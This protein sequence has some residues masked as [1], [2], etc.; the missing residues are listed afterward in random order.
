M[1]KNI[2]QKIITI[3]LFILTVGLV[4]FYQQKVIAQNTPDDIAK[5]YNIT[6]PIKELNNC[7]NYAECRTFCEDPINQT[8]CVNFAKT[9]GFYHEENVDK[10]EIQDAAKIELGCTDI[11]SCKTICQN[12]AN[13]DKC[14]AFAKKHNINGGEGENPEKKEIVEKAKVALGCD[15]PLSCRSICEKVENRQKCDDFAKKAGL[16]GGERRTGP[17]GCTSEDSCRTFCSD[18]N[19]FQICSNFTKGAKGIKGP[20]EQFRGPGGCTSEETCKKFCQDHPQECRMERREG[21]TGINQQNF[22]SQQEACFKTPGC[23]W[24]NNTCQCGQTGNQG[25]FGSSGKPFETEKQ[26]MNPSNFPK[27]NFNPSSSNFTPPSNPQE[28]CSKRGCRWDNN[29]CRCG[30]TQPPSAPPANQNQP[31]PSNQSDHGSSSSGPKPEDMCRQKPGCNWQD[32]TCKCSDVKGVSTGP[33]D[34][35]FRTVFQIINSLFNSQ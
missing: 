13:I 15:S 9:K 27:Q 5:K 31:P 22:N 26:M 17:G 33:N 10:K 3:C 19:N 28:E 11:V 18:P 8:T 21:Q 1:R 4:F 25:T 6:F 16:R 24:D 12:E 29:S 34:N 14:S 20:E 32:N 23:R 2:F 7:K 35:F 30:N